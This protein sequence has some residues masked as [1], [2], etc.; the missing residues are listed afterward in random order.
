[1]KASFYIATFCLISLNIFLVYSR[2]ISSTRSNGKT[3]VS[4][5]ETNDEYMLRAYFNVNKT[6]KV[7]EYLN[8][9]LKPNS[10][11]GS[12]NDYFNANT[13]LTDNTELHIRKSPGK[14]E[15]KLNKRINSYSSYCR[16]KKMCDGVSDVL[17]GK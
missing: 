8:K 7:Q 10:L 13:M 2:I 16:I 5:V 11:F 4:I 9:C 17:S 15:I 3:S 6:A 14:L 12:E 1:M